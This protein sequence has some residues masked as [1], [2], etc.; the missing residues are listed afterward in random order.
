MHVV[1]Q[2]FTQHSPSDDSGHAC[3]MAKSCCHPRQG[4]C[5]GWEKTNA[6]AKAKAK[7]KQ[8]AKPETEDV[9]PKPV[10][11][12]KPK[13]APSQSLLTNLVRCSNEMSKS[14]AWSIVES[15]LRDQIATKL[16]I[17]PLSE[18]THHQRLQH[19]Q[20]NI[21]TLV[22]LGIWHTP[23]QLEVQ[24]KTAIMESAEELIMFHVFARLLSWMVS[25]VLCF[26]LLTSCDELIVG[27][28]G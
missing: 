17:K 14:S 8:K 27:N 16:K 23:A 7:A 25:C 13:S 26:F 6:K 21:Q 12:S 11:E 22:S 1:Y 9:K 2:L 24:K 4:S 5:G 15:A 10:P 19:E 18:L 28:D 20:Q 3:R